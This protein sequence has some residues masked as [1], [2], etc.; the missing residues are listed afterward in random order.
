[1]SDFFVNKFKIFDKSFLGYKN[2]DVILQVFRK[3]FAILLINYLKL[4]RFVKG[5][6]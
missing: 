3:N 6:K 2:N 1:M 5:T 4:E